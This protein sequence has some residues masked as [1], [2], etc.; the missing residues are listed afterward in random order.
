MG[1]KNLNFHYIG[2]VN[3]EQLIIFIETIYPEYK[4][5]FIY[6]RNNKCL[7]SELD[8]EFYY[9]IIHGVFSIESCN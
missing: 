8:I 5:K 7:S 6:D 3:P 9:D 2:I 4:G 1:E